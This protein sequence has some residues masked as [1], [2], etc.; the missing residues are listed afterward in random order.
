LDFRGELQQLEVL[1]QLLVARDLPAQ[2][3]RGD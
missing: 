1:H 2:P 3:D